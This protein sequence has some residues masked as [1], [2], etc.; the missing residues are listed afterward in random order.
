MPCGMLDHA[1]C[2]S[3]RYV[4]LLVCPTSRLVWGR[5]C[6]RSAM[7]ITR[8]CSVGSLSQIHRRRRGQ[9]ICGAG[10]MPACLFPCH[11]QQW[12]TL[13]TLCQTVALRSQGTRR[14]WMYYLEESEVCI[15]GLHFVEPGSGWLY[16]LVLYSLSQGCSQL[17]V[18]ILEPVADLCSSLITCTLPEN[19]PQSVEIL[20]FGLSC[21][22]TRDTFAVRLNEL[23]AAVLLQNVK[24]KVVTITDWLPKVPLTNGKIRQL[25]QM[26]EALKLLKKSQSFAGGAGTG[27]CCP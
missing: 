2:N 1:F 22:K 17:K 4:L 3:Y 16:R 11:E 15:I 10:D 23:G 20:S 5:P 21:R 19:W 6:L 7:N 26:V 18:G 9:A 24:I 14:V 13:L 25:E 12:D 8:H 27:L